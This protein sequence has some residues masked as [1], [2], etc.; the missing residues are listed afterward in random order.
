M[1]THPGVIAAEACALLGFLTAHAIRDD[2]LPL[3]PE[4]AAAGGAGRWLEK[5]NAETTTSC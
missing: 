5:T 3:T 4:G 2:T 1:S